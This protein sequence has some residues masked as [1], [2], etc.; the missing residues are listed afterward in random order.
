MST[1]KVSRKSISWFFKF[2]PAQIP[3]AIQE[4]KCEDAKLGMSFYFQ[5]IAIVMWILSIL[6][7][8]KSQHGFES[9]DDNSKFETE[10]TK[11]EKNTNV[12]SMMF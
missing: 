3:T 8:F 10:K 4:Y 7:G 1:E 2:R 11:D 9:I 12:E 6:F 5:I